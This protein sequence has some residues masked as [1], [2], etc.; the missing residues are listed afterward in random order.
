MATKAAATVTE[1]RLAKVYD[2]LQAIDPDDLREAL[3]AITEG[4]PMQRSVGDV[5]DPGPELDVGEGGAV[6]T[7]DLSELERIVGVNNQLPVH[8]LE[9]GV[10]VQRAV[11]RVKLKVAH[12][13]LPAGSG[14]GTGSLVSPSLLLTNNH[15]IPTKA[16]AKKVAAE[17]NY[18]F[19][20][21]GAA[22][23]SDSFDLDPDAFFLTNAALDYTLV[24]VKSKRWSFVLQ[25]SMGVTGGSVDGGLTL[26][27]RQPLTPLLLWRT[28]GQSFGWLR[29]PSSGVSYAVGQYLNVVGHPAG[30][31]RRS[32]SRTTASPTCTP[33]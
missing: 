9:E 11:A 31:A 17:F 6:A 4:A 26:I 10:V 12:S 7:E 5:A 2:Q 27:D 21:N 32:P 33:T 13:G 20:F 18:Q 23:P 29:L 30:R 1:N 19:D 24:R 15:V 25:P 3:L 16:F 8:F 28:P 22:L 14:W